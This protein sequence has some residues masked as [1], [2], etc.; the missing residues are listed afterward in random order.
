MKKQ[1]LLLLCLC[2]VGFSQAQTLA[3]SVVGAGGGRFSST[4]GFLDWTLG[5]IMTETYQKGNF[6]FTQGFQQPATIVVTGLDE[7]EKS[8]FVYPNPLSD[9]LNIKTSENGDYLILLFDMQGKQLVNKNVSG[10]VGTYI[11]QIDLAGYRPALYLLR[12]N[13]TITG[14]STNHKIEK[15]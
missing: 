2:I 12:I 10:V 1:T 7:T 9:V 15:L 14:K 4:T 6:Y 11:H 5:E 3:S 8:V 13:N